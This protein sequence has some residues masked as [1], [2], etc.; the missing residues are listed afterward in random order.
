[1]NFLKSPNRAVQVAGVMASYALLFLCFRSD[2]PFPEAF[3]WACAGVMVSGGA[4]LA[5]ERH[6]MGWFYAAL[7]IVQ[8]IDPRGRATVSPTHATVALSI[9]A[10]LLVVTAVATFR[11][12][13]D[14]R[15]A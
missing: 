14:R 6:R 9:L 13:R 3:V 10:A 12:V 15:T 7:G 8:A 4:V 2:V 1:M 5:S 11:Q